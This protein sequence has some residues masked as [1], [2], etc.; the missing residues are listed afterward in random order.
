MSVVTILGIEMRSG[1]NYLH[2]LIVKHPQ[3]SGA[4]GIW[5]DFV[6]ADLQYVSKYFSVL[7]TFWQKFPFD[8]KN[9]DKSK[10]A[11]GGVLID[12]LKCQSTEKQEFSYLV[13]KT[14]SFVGIEKAPE[15]FPNSKFLLLI[16]DGRSVAYSLEKS[17]NVNYFDALERW[18]ES[19]R[20]LIEFMESHEAF[21]RQQ[22][23]L[24]KYEDIFLDSQAQLSD[25][26][27]FLC[28]DPDECNFSEIEALEVRGSSDLRAANQQIDWKKVKRTQDF[29]PIGRFKAWPKWKQAY[30]DFY[31]RDELKQF[32]YPLEA[33]IGG[34]LPTPLVSGLHVIERLNPKK[35]QVRMKKWLKAQLIDR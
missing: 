5:E 9:I 31:C 7:E 15:F 4:R 22:C 11:F 27:R 25:I 14:P 16:R 34:W 30:A 13:T 24:V 12:L 8:R 10:E 28:L 1:T 6:L 19:A 18:R 21:F 29:N 20:K 17:F 3:C 33:E 32:G 23:F 2:D 35:L 26:F